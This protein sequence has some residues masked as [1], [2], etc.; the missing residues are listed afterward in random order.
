MPK[1][2]C[3][4]CDTY[5]THD[6]PSVRKTHNGG[7]RHKDNVRL[8]YMNWLEKQAQSMMNQTGLRMGLRPI[9]PGLLTAPGMMPPVPPGLVMPPP[10]MGIPPRPGLLPPGMQLP[11][12]PPVGIP[13]PPLAGVVPNTFP[14]PNNIPPPVTNLSLIHI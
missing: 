5:L 2:Y 13:P 8:Y 9:A 1:Y 4:Y 12:P 6:S 11:R 3:D 10:P 7:R 14:P